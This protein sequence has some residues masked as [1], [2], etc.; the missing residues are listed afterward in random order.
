MYKD[1]RSYQK[2]DPTGTTKKVQSTPGNGSTRVRR[3]RMQEDLIKISAAAEWGEMAIS[4]WHGLPRD[5]S[6]RYN[7]CVKC[8]LEGAREGRTEEHV[9]DKAHERGRAFES[10]RDRAS[11]CSDVQRRRCADTQKSL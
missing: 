4:V 3:R 9:T 1:T 7:D 6:R 10:R 2:I 8:S 11:W 5:V